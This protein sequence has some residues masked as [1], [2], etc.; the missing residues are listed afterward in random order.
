[1]VS[2]ISHALGGTCEIDRHGGVPAPGEVARD[3]ASVP[4]ATD[5]QRTKA[6][7]GSGNDL[8]AAI[9]G[10][11]VVQPGRRAPSLS[12]SDDGFA[13]AEGPDASGLEVELARAERRDLSIGS[14][15][16]GARM[17][18]VRC[19]VDRDLGGYTPAWW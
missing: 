13:A 6:D 16:T 5:G 12:V 18:I 8:I 17:R 19:M 4:T 14:L 11:P 2:V 15:G 3:A 1:M 9:A 7:H 10:G